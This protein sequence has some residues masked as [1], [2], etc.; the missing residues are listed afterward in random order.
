MRLRVKAKLNRT[1]VGYILAGI[2]MLFACLYLRFPG[3]AFTD[4]VRALTAQNPWSLLSSDRIRP[5]FP[6]GLALANV[7]IGARGRPEAN[8][9]LDD[10]RVRPG[11][12]SL[13]QG[14]LTL[15][16]AAKGYGGDATGR[17]DFSRLLS[18]GGP[19]AAGATLRDVRIEKCAWLQDALARQVTGT[20]RG[21]VSVGG[22][23]EA[24][25]HMT[26]NVDFTLAN[27]VVP[28]TDGFFDIKKID[29]S[30]IEGKFAF[31]K[32]TM[33]I[34]QLALTGEKLR[35]SLKG[36]ILVAD[37]FPES[38]ID[39]SGTIELPGQGSRRLTLNISGTI[40]NP[41]TRLM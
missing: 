6:P 38:R 10:I 14:R 35:L 34:T 7:T 11:G 4:D 13:L 40:D 28:L 1:V 32:G 23:M 39:L 41:R 22:T 20:L 36:D 29:F 16:L 33:K 17:I 21:T 37:P 2:A 26:W 25:D 8:I 24:P 15:L 18:L 5:T 9:R 19:L 3:E 12:L 27:G 31:Q 30:R